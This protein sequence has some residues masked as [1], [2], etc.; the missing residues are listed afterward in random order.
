MGVG[1]S[2]TFATGL[3][4]ALGMAV[5]TILAAGF[6]TTTITQNLIPQANKEGE[7]GFA[8]VLFVGGSLFYAVLA[9]VVV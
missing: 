1:S 6:L 3:L 2:L 9:L 5:S 7:P 8:G 4:L